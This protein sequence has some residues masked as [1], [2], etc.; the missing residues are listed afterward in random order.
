[1][2]TSDLNLSPPAPIEELSA[3]E[4]ELSVPNSI[5][6]SESRRLCAVRASGL[7]DSGPEQAYDELAQLAAY[8]CQTPI[9]LITLVDEYRQWFK[10]KVGTEIG[11]TPIELSFCVH[12]LQ[13]DDLFVVPDAREDTR[14]SANAIVAGDP[15][16]RFY[17]GYPL[18]TSSGAKLGTLCVL[19]KVPRKL[20]PEQ[21]MALRVL[22][23]QVMS[24]I[25]LKRQIEA[26]YLAMQEKQEAERALHQTQRE[27]VRANAKLRTLSLTDPLTGLKNRRAF[28]AALEQEFHRT[29]RSGSPLS[30]LLLDIDSFK[31]FNDAHGHVQGDEVLRRIAFLMQDCTRKSDLV[32]RYG[33]EEF[34]AILP[35]TG[36]GEALLLA[37]RLCDEIAAAHWE[38]RQ[39]T[40]SIGAATLQPGTPTPYAFVNVADKALYTAKHGGKNQVCL[41]PC[42]QSDL[43]SHA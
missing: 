21:Q 31:S 29:R 4:D 1:M 30:L 11:E 2:L 5:L 38:Y 20:T 12:A 3:G 7:L 9:S 25:E 24:Q 18:S 33:G 37:T 43:A 14:F 17:A 8:I 40:V 6:N 19:D 32:A 15:F 35:D 23:R 22:A 27:L 42:Y 10:A 41:A 16:I 26:L 36:D 39:I 28:E 13:Q 34:V